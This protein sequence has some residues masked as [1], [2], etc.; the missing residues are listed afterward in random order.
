VQ[1][2]LAHGPKQ[3]AQAVTAF[4]EILRLAR[5]PLLARE[6]DGSTF[7]RFLHGIA[8]SPSG[9]NRHLPLDQFSSDCQ[10]VVDRLR[11]FLIEPDDHVVTSSW[12]YD[13][14]QHSAFKPQDQKALEMFFMYGLLQ[15][16][17]AI[18]LLLSAA[19]QTHV[20]L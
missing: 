6:L 16:E 15:H 20:H 11:R 13:M 19:I 9:L 3:N 8:S 2:L 18:D 7:L 14:P 1:Q 10:T 4:L 12:Q 17:R 5:T